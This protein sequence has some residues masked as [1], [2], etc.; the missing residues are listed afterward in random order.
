MQPMLSLAFAGL[1][2][3]LTMAS[4]DDA[5]LAEIVAQRLHGD[6]TGACFAVAV[7]E[8]EVARAH[9]CADGADAPRIGPLHTF[10]IG[11][12]A[13]TMT[14]ALLADQMLRGE[15]SLDDPLARHLPPGTVVPEFEGHPIRLRHMVTHTS[16]LPALP[17]R[18]RFASMADPYADLREDD[19]L[20]SLA[21][22]VLDA[23]PGTHFAYSNFAG[24]VLS[25]A[26][27]RHA[28]VD[29]EDLI[30]QRLFE[31]LGMD[32]AHVA[33]RPESVTPAQ[34]HLPNGMPTAAWNIPGNLAGVGG[35][36]ASLDDMIRYAQGHL[37]R[38]DAPITPAL[39]LSRQPLADSRMP[40][41]MH[42]MLAPLDGRA[43]HLHEGG[44]GGFSSFLAID[45]EQDR[46]VII[47]SDTALTSLGGLGDLGRHLLDA[48]LPLGAPRR[49]AVPSDEL[50]DHL[51]GRYE[52]AG[53]LG[54]TLTRESD[55]LVIQATGQPAFKMGYD[56]AGDFFP[57][58]FDALLKPR[59]GVDGW[60]FDWMQGGAVIPA[61]RLDAMQLRQHGAEQ[62]GVRE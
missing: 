27:A 58:V 6:R 4:L 59:R 37:G 52:L 28:G 32:G 35:V 25:L 17:A 22:V 19:L 34:G 26:L 33:R 21:D 15:A 23:P 8:A 7:V 60:T 20:A 43:V 38:T 29:F 1:L 36:R 11:S 55:A 41:A 3:P 44:T 31:P 18:M 56:S 16:G 45:R 47:L 62:R 46:A 49:L 42:W 54:V 61:T 53:G 14:A 12:I 51:V 57:L 40:M 48:R 13:K 50:L 5:R 30:R 39:D 24:M 10:E 2:T 9:V